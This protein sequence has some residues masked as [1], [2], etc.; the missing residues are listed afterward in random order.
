MILNRT[1]IRVIGAWS[2]PFLYLK[3]ISTKVFSILPEGLTLGNSLEGISSIMKSIRPPSCSVLLSLYGGVNP[4]KINWLKENVSSNFVSDTR[5]ILI[6][7]P[8]TSFSISNLFR[9]ELMFKW[10]FMIRFGFFL[11]ILFNTSFL[12]SLQRKFHS[13]DLWQIGLTFQYFQSL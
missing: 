11:R 12:A 7:L 4:Y 3:L 10:P 8:I 5:K 9:I 13:R 6:L 2:K 1:D